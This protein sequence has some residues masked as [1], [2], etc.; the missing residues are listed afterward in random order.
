MLKKSLKRR[1]VAFSENNS[2]I[3]F[4]QH[5]L[6]A[7]AS[8]EWGPPKGIR[9]F[10]I[11]PLTHFQAIFE[12]NQSPILIKFKAPKSL[13]FHG[14]LNSNSFKPTN[15]D[16]ANVFGSSSNNPLEKYVN[17]DYD[18]ENFII[19]FIIQF[20]H[21]GQYGL[22][23]Y[24][25]DPDYQAEKRTMSHCCKY[26]INYT[27]PIVGSPKQG[28]YNDYSFDRAKMIDGKPILMPRAHSTLQKKDVHH[29]PRKCFVKDFFVLKEKAP[30]S[31]LLLKV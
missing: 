28:N 17:Y 4:F 23:L 9:H 11:Q 13:K 22:D 10:N 31:S 14:K 3:F 29:S 5:P 12:T 26:I 1:L 7:C 21:E 27:K 2:F 8:G 30:V 18:Q 15:N 25:R 20:P 24:A 16:Q 19:T 6:P